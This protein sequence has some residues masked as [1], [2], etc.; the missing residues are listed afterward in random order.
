MEEGRREE[1]GLAGVIG[2][3]TEGGEEGMG[4]RKER[5][6]QGAKEREVRSKTIE[7]DTDRQAEAST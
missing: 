3:K 2:K 1:A 7:G 4:R 6:G 5:K